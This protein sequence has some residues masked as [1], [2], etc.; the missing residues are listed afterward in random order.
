MIM[1]TLNGKEKKDFGLV[2]MHLGV[3]LSRAQL[4]Y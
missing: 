2:V 3:K 1:I 4:F